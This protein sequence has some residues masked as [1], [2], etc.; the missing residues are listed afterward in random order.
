MQSN[1]LE[2][3]SDTVNF[4]ELKKVAIKFLPPTSTLRKVIL[5]E[6]DTLTRTSA[7][8]KLEIYVRLLYSE[9]RD[10]Q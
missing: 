8:A 7:I 1:T 6:P 4:S 9:L 2:H 10:N 5:S 3:P